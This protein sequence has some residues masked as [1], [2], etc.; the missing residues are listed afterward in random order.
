M[1]KYIPFNDKWYD[2]NGS[3]DPLHRTSGFTIFCDKKWKNI[4]SEHN[5]D[6][7]EQSCGRSA[8]HMAMCDLWR[9]QDDK[10]K[11]KYAV[12]L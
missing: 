5:N 11:A 8:A 3:R 9:E 1:S 10:K 12:S 6:V 4:V 2:K 7:I